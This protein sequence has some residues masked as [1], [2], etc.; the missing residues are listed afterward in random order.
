MHP[1]TRQSKPT[2][3]PRRVRLDTEASDTGSRGPTAAT[4]GNRRGID[5]AAD[6]AVRARYGSRERQRTDWRS[7]QKPRTRVQFPPSPPQYEHEW[8]SRRML[9]RGRPS[10]STA[11]AGGSGRSCTSATWTGAG[12]GTAPARPTAAPTARKAHDCLARVQHVPRRLLRA[13]FP[14]EEILDADRGR[15]LTVVTAGCPSC[16]HGCSREIGAF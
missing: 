2:H 11:G 1:R 15:P 3:D 14:K 6:P 10:P 13:K 5:E 8:S 7:L 9:R 12:R 16:R 4:E